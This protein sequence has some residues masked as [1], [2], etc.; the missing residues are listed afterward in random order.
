VS[1]IFARSE[2]RCIGRDG[3]VPWRLPDEME[4]FKRTT[5]GHPVVM[6]RRTY[7]DHESALPGRLNLVVTSRPALPLP[8][9]VERA[10]TLEAALAR[11]FEVSREVFVIGG[12]DLLLRALPLADRVYE[13]VVHARIEGDT[14]LPPLDLEGWPATLLH[15]HPADARHA[16]AWTATR[17]DR[18]AADGALRETRPR[19]RESG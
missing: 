4:H 5:M 9:D 10:P 15:R 3:R 8:A 6:G 18:P 1:L 17:Y 12:A 2:N 16:Y 11:G 7:E 19:A 14:F 13:T